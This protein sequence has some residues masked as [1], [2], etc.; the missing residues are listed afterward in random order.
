MRGLSSFWL[1]RPTLLVALPLLSVWA[2]LV[3]FRGGDLYETSAYRRGRWTRWT[4]VLMGTAW[5]YK[6]IATFV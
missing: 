2:L 4:L 6:L 3:H 5:V 1:R